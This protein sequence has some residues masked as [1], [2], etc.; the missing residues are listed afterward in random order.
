MKYYTPTAQELAAAHDAFTANE[1]RDLFYRAA[2]ELVDRVIQGQSSLSVPE[3]LA[4]LLQT[5]NKAVYQYKKFDNQHFADIEG[6]VSEHEEILTSYRPR[7]IATL[8]DV[9]TVTIKA[10]FTRFEEVLGPVG[11]AKSLHLLVPRFLPLWDRA[12]AYAYDCSFWITSLWTV[13]SPRRSSSTEDA[14]KSES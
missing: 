14:G 7:A 10:I 8:S 5:W 1:A 11:A 4:V 3:A 12:I 6:V 13:S 2:T 9:E